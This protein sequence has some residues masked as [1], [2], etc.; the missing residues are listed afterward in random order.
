MQTGLALIPPAALL[1]LLIPALASSAPQPGL[2]CAQ[3]HLDSATFDGRFAG[4]AF[5]DSPDDG[6]VDA[7]EFSLL[8]RQGRLVM[9]Q[10]TSEVWVAKFAPLPNNTQ[11]ETALTD[12]QASGFRLA[13]GYRILVIPGGPETRFSGVAGNLSVAAASDPP[14]SYAPK[15]SAQRPAMVVQ[16]RDAIELAAQS[17]TITVQAP[18]TLVLWEANFTLAQQGR[19]EV[20]HTGATTQPFADPA[21]AGR[22]VQREAYF[23][24]TDG[25]LTMPATAYVGEVSLRADGQTQLQDPEGTLPIKGT[26]IPAGART[27]AMSGPFTAVMNTAQGKLAV[28]FDREPSQLV[29][30]GTIVRSPDPVG[31]RGAL[32]AWLAALAALGLMGAFVFRH[33]R[34]RRMGTV[35]RLIKEGNYADALAL[36]RRLGKRNED[37]RLAQ[38]T[39][40]IQQKD[41]GQ[42]RALLEDHHAWSPAAR[43]MQHYLLATVAGGQGRKQAATDLLVRCLVEAPALLMEALANPLLADVVKDALQQRTGAAGP[44]S[45]A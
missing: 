43:P 41:F 5:E 16:G 4:A 9:D 10:E 6:P 37:A 39:C 31:H 8:A 29:L 32:A 23:E 28:A 35:M 13:P 17:G 45:Y 18:F 21:P 33:Q 19:S 34:K 12:A 7:G 36:A 24:V 26:A 14:H 2:Y 11:D 42:A 44:E 3:A 38:A 30:D 27:L 15:A 20:V 40:L 25:T 1:F 22:H